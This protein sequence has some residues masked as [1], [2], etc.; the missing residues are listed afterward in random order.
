V[1]D[2]TVVICT[3]NRAELLEATLSSLAEQRVD[4]NLAWDIV[5]V[6]NN[7]SDGTLEVAEQAASRLPLT[8]VFEGRQGLS[9]ARNSGI[10]AARGEIVAFTD[11]DVL[12]ASDWIASISSAVRRWGADIVGG[13]ILPKWEG[14]PPGWLL[15]NDELLANLAMLTSERVRIFESSM[16]E[17]PKI[18]GANMAFRRSVFSRIELF[19]TRRGIQGKMLYRGEETELI[20]RAI[21]AGSVAVYDPSLVVFHRIGSDRMRRGY[22]RRLHFQRALGEVLALG[23]R[24]V[25]RWRYRRV[26]ELM[27]RWAGRVLSGKPGAFGLELDLLEE[28]GAIAGG[29]YG[30]MCRRG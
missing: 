20:A 19:D 26:A 8:Y 7:S 12:P 17:N 13:R 6:D 11:D 27:V 9:Q 15:E 25:S 3:Y 2:L 30:R 29:A 5:L 14:T 18:W 28:L 10:A 23:H 24:G 16:R 4:G 1:T 21:G 22:F